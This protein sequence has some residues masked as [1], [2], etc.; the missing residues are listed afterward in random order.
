MS[1]K[2][3]LLILVSAHIGF[4]SM[5]IGSKPLRLS[6]NSRPLVVKT[7]SLPPP[8]PNKLP[9]KQK[10]ASIKSP[11]KK[12]PVPIRQKKKPTVPLKQATQEFEIP[13]PILKQLEETIAK[14]AQKDDKQ[15]KSNTTVTA[16]LSPKAA[17]DLAI[18]EQA[19][20]SYAALLI[21]ELTQTLQLPEY[22]EV[23]VKLTINP[24]GKVIKLLVLETES[25]ANKLYLEENLPRIILPKYQEEAILNKEQTF[26]LTFCNAL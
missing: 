26:N 1:H 2:I 16:S 11:T 5:L 23:K 20:S 22:G 24:M 15:C 17:V 3:L 14:I 8:S 19:L 12:K 6:K 10:I 13:S 25:T 4:L 7:I 9:L 18:E 21:K